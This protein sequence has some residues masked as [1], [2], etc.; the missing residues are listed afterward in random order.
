MGSTL[1][2]VSHESQSKSALCELSAQPCGY[3]RRD[4]RLHG[5]SASRPRRRRDSSPR[6]IRVAAAA[7]PRRV[8]TDYPRSR[9][10]RCALD[11][12]PAAGTPRRSPRSPPTPR[13]R[14]P[15]RPRPRSRSS[16]RARGS[17]ASAWPAGAT[18]LY[19][20]RGGCRS[21]RNCYSVL[22]LWLG[23]LFCHLSARRR[24]FSIVFAALACE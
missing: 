11:S 5:L 14:C 1:P 8:S 10:R 23:A 24:P 2:I 7:P 3:L 12:H 13:G 17:T 16:R 20:A 21:L 4:A 18:E 9:R 19:G 6:S 15:I 22:G